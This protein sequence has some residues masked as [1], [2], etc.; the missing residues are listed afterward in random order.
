MLERKVIPEVLDHLA[1]DDPEALRSRRDLHRIH[2]L[3]GNERWVLRAVAG[4][5]QAVMRGIVE[6]EAGDGQL[7]GKLARR[8]QVKRVAT[9][10]VEL[11][12]ATF[13]GNYHPGVLI[14]LRLFGAGGA[15][16]IASTV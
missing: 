6:L 12:P 11:S 10:A 2:F 8:Y 3:M 9:V 15:T 5:Q 13:F 7:S 14:R 16:G 1:A 4:F